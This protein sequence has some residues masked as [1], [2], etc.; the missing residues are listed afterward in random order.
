M[1]F[2]LV[3]GV[4]AA[5]LVL[6][7][8]GT[9]QYALMTMLV[10]LPSL[11]TF[12]DL[13][14]G[15]VVV[16]SIATATD[17]RNNEYLERQVT[18]VVR[19]ILIFVA[20]VALVS[21]ILLVT[22]GWR[23]VLGAAYI[24]KNS[25]TAA[26]L[27]AL[28]YCGTAS[29][30]IWQRT[31]LGLGKNPTIILLQ[32]IISPLSLLMVWLTLTT[33]DPEFYSFLA[34]STFV[35][36]FATATLG[37]II[38]DRYTAPLLREVAR[39]VFHPRK[40]P[41][42]RVMNVGWPMLIQLLSA[43]LSIALP[44]YI[45]AQSVGPVELAQYALAGQVFFALQALVSAAGV[46]LWPSFARARASKAQVRGP[47]LLSVIFGLAAVLATVTMIAIGPW[48]FAI[49]SSN[50]VEVPTSLILAFGTMVLLQAIVYPLGMF[51]MDPPGIRFQVIPALAMTL[52]TVG[53]SAISTPHLGVLGPSLSNAASVCLFQVIP[54]LIYIR[55]NHDRLYGTDNK[56]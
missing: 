18:T 11:I 55:R 25:S 44:R 24:D 3:C 4:A 52:S 45:M 43:P 19:V 33:R 39:R 23:F 1:I 54:Y 17:V 28:V 9:E 12:S 51:I 14:T 6:G 41:G 35:A 56:T 30:G 50:K 27:C 26:W 10:A 7:V 48:F 36:T 22:G 2:S 32:G 34:L 8:A 53:L 42:V 47:H 15:A 29:L 49:V 20:A 38:A 21:S 46:S 13:G 5:R 40:F 37:I 31:L 16:N